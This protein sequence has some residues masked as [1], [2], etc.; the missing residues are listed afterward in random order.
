MDKR[1]ISRVDAMYGPCYGILVLSSFRASPLGQRPKPRST[2]RRKTKKQTTNSQRQRENK[3]M[4]QAPPKTEGKE[5]IDTNNQTQRN[6]HKGTTRTQE[7]PAAKE[8]LTS[9]KMMIRR[10]RHELSMSSR[11]PDAAVD[12]E[13]EEIPY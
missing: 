13:L 1:P 4:T 9:K 3:G 6:K 2:Q 7:K 5:R 11:V 8:W 10:S 12:G